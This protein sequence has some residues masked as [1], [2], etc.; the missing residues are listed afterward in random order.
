MKPQGPG[1][2]YGFATMSTDTGHNSTS[3]DGAWAYTHPERVANWGHLAMHGSVVTSKIITSKFYG[4]NI[5]YSYYAGCSTGGRQGLKEAEAYPED[6]DGIIAGAPAWW[7]THLQTWTDKVALFNLPATAETRIPPALFPVIAAEVL[8]QCDPQDGLTD[9][10]ISSPETCDFKASALACDSNSSNS[11]TCL[12][13]PQL[14][15]LDHI[16]SDWVNGNGTFVFPHLQHGSE[17]QWLLVAGVAPNGLGTEFV[18][19][20]LGLGPDW[21]FNTFTDETVALAERINPGN[22]TV[23]YDLSKFNAKGGKIL[24]YHGL[25]DGLIPTGTT[26]YFYEQ[27][28]K[29][30][31]GTNL[32]TFFRFFLVPGM[33]HCSGT[34]AAMNAP[35]YFAGPNQ[36]P[37]L[38]PEVYSVPGFEDREHDAML[39]M[40]AWVEE[41]KAPEQII[42]TKF[43]N[44]TMHTAVMRQR[45]L[46]MYPKQAKYTGTGDVNAAASW[47]C[48][49]ANITFG[50]AD[51]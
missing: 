42:G 32:D 25:S 39:A 34:S 10:I 17:G 9:T 8:R 22:A 19:Y 51:W 5:T 29:V 11:T 6:F 2:R 16:Y 20:F 28:K 50:S 1:V 24:A 31:N 18:K 7:T 45:P 12:T 21:D 15:T 49:A 44:D 40:M 26:P 43:V 4:E 27:V 41:G 23:G 36:A 35:W 30:L 3:S 46:C 37:V 14:E 13:V 47:S 33:Q 38:G 48:H